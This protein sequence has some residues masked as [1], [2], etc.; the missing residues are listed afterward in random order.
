MGTGKKAV[1][2]RGVALQ[3]LVNCRRRGAWSDSALSSAIRSAGLSHRDAALASRICY[4]VQQNQMLLDFWLGKLCSVPVDK[5]ELPVCCAMELAMYQI[6][7][8]ERIPDAAAVNESVELARFNSRN[9]NSP[10]LVNGV[11]RSFVRQ[12]ENLPHPDSLSVAYS[13]P[14][15]LVEL[16]AQELEGEGVEALLAADNSQPPTVIHT[17]PLKTSPEQLRRRLEE[18][19]VTVGENPYFAES[20]TLSGSGDLEHLGSFREGWFLVQDTAARL[21]V[22]AAGVQSGMEALDVCAAPGGKSFQ[23]AMQMGDQGSII[24]CDLQ[25][26]KLKRLTEGAS[27][28]GIGCIQAQAADG[29]VFQERWENRFDVVL[30]D[31]PCS[32]LGI[33][34]KKPDIRYKEPQPLSALPAIQRDILTNASR[35]VK[36]GGVLAYSTCTVLRRENQQVVEDFLESHKD[37]KLEPFVLPVIGEC[38]GMITLWPHIHQTDGFFMAKLRKQL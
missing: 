10:R 12:R 35:Y 17:N 16:F 24:S 9:S 34:R 29:R 1:S 18:E 23:M 8:L 13:H 28:L 26:K 25:E 5:L 30:T 27:R 4:G 19:G 6:T 3:V 37:F 32:G 15:W 38:D 33:I 20:F 2:A 22:E 36:P 31:V 14:Q 11:L 21:A 7:F